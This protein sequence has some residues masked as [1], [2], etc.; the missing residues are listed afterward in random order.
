MAKMLDTLVD[1]YVQMNSQAIFVQNVDDKYRSLY[2]EATKN[3]LTQKI[4]DEIKSE[5]RENAVKD[6]EKEIDQKAGLKRIDEFKKLMVQGFFV[7]IFVGLFVNQLTD[8][9]GFLKGTITIESIW[10]TVIIALVFFLICVGIFTWLFAT[11]LIKLLKR[12]KND[13]NN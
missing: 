12:E 9:I 10:T 1:N 4:Y 11:E 6:A 3:E 5:V 8:A 7:A 13:E 2:I